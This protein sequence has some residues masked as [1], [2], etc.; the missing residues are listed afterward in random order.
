MNKILIISLLTCLTFRLEA[1]VQTF[2]DSLKIE[3]DAAVSDSVKVKLLRRAFRFYY[4]DNIDTSFWLTKETLRLNSKIKDTLGIAQAQL[5]MASLY[6]AQGNF[7]EALKYDRKAY[8]NLL[9]VNDEKGLVASLNGLGEDYL[10]L[11]LYNEAFSYYQKALERADLSENKLMSAIATYNIGRVFKATGQLAKSAEFIRQSMVLSEQIDDKVGQAYSLNDLGEIFFLQ[12]EAE[13]ALSSLETALPI[14]QDLD[15]D[16]IISDIMMN[17]ALAHEAL[18]K[19]DSAL[20]YYDRAAKLYEKQVNLIELAKINLQRGKI[21]LAEG[22]TKKAKVLFDSSLT[23]GLQ[24]NNPELLA[25]AWSNLSEWH[26]SAGNTKKGLEMLRKSIALK[27]SLKA[28]NKDQQFSQTIMEFEIGRKDIAIAEL[29]AQEQLRQKELKNEEFIR[30]V[31]VVILAFTAILLFTLYR[32]SVRSRKANQLLIDHQSEIEAK[33]KELESLLSMKDKFFS[34]VSHDL[35]SPINGLVGILD[36]LHEGHITQDELVK[37]TNSLKLRLES[38]RKMLDKLLD[39][40]LVEMNEITL[41]WEEI[42]LQKAVED[43][44][45]FFKEINDKNISFDNN[46]SAGIGVMADRNMLDLILRNLIA[47]AI[48]FMTEEGTVAISS[49]S[50]NDLVTISVKDTGVGMDANQIEKIFD[51][52]I[53]YTT[54]GTANEKG[55]GLGL[56]LCKE[57][58][59]K[60]G[61]TIWVE[62]EEDKGSTFNFT[63]D[64]T[65]KK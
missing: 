13:S 32:N 3:Y 58:V 6:N 46:I 62:S 40:A 8:E 45:A 52:N 44:L 26:E 64:K 39:W 22:D 56:K 17:M 59:E 31:L 49:T 28:I 57:F 11:G 54:K 63:L 10:G 2:P 4:V 51:S 41:K 48:K 19:T 37:V 35:R 65:S 29:N 20:Y 5:D 23:T 15:E 16:I 34:I 61:G 30:N 50:S 53:L 14:A 7:G 25:S 42:N 12:G 21:F 43:N 55:T 27:D 60:M 9:V 47:N 18:E 36:L 24:Q 1:W 33:T 38:T